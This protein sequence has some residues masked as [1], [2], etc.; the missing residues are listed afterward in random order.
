MGKE[1]PNTSI[2][3]PWIT[4]FFFYPFDIL[5]KGHKGF[6]A[7]KQEETMFLIEVTNVCPG[8]DVNLCQRNFIPSSDLSDGG[9][10]HVWPRP[11]ISVGTLFRSSVRK[12]H[13]PSL[14]SLL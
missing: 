4:Y 8:N 13:E 2:P 11:L 3:A 1:Y 6:S 14:T 5:K 7:I 12:G 10:A 9:T